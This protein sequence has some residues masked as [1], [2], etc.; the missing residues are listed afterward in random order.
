MFL[1][2]GQVDR[3]EVWDAGRYSCEALN[4]AGRSEK[5]YNLNVWGEGLLGWGPSPCWL[6][7]TPPL[8]GATLNGSQDTA[9]LHPALSLGSRPGGP[10]LIPARSSLP[11]PHLLSALTQSLRSSPPRSPAP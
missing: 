2:P 11:P 10:F 4:Q 3:A 5:H 9:P 8:G 7:S 6:S 1:A